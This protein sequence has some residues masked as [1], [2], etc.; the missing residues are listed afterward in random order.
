[1]ISNAMATFGGAM[2]SSC[3]LTD[4]ESLFVSQV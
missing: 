2:K 4:L 1:M 3:D